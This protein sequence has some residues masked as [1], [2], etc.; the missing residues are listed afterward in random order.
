VLRTHFTLKLVLA[1]TE[2]AAAAKLAARGR[3]GG[4]VRAT[5][6]AQ[7]SAFV[8]GTPEQV[9]AHYRALAEVGI[10]YFVVQL[11]AGDEETLRLFAEDVMPHV[12]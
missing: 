7:P 4:G 3:G 2:A 10:Q 12:G 6:R 9:T 8:S 11:D 5:R 1:P